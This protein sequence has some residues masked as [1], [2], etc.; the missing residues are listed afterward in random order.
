M[1]TRTMI[2][3]PGNIPRMMI[4]GDILG[5]DIMT[6]D[7]ED[8]VTPSQK[9]SA[10]VL[11]KNFLAKGGP[12]KSQIA[13]RTNHHATKYFAKD[14]EYVVPFKPLIMAPKIDKPEDIVFLD[15][16]LLQEEKKNGFEPGTIKVLAILETAMGVEHAYAIATARKRVIALCLGAEDLS[17]DLR[18]VRTKK[19]NEILYS[20]QRIVL[21]ARA[22]DIKSFDTVFTDVEDIA[23]LIEDAK[24]AKILGFDGK[25]LISPRHID[26]VNEIFS[27]TQEE[28]KYAQQVVAAME[29]GIREGKGAVALNGKMIDPPVYDRARQVIEC[30]RQL[31]ILGF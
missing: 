22:A 10:R 19:G 20:R 15:E 8:G 6:L 11:I 1:L 4:N 16:A 2:M 29:E 30:A 17:A 7:L 13:V 24:F 21:A 9:D 18:A 26:T 27:P 12:F 25:A 31:G 3:I 14:L 28:I 5:A 23:G